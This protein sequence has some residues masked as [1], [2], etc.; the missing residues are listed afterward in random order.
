MIDKLIVGALLS[1]VGWNGLHPAEPVPM[2]PSQ[3]QVKAKDRSISKVCNKKKKSKKV[4][5]LCTRW[6]KHDA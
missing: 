3:L 5:E 4:K 2:T 1:I 6:G